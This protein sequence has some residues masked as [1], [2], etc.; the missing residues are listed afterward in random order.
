M[1]TEKVLMEVIQYWVA[2][3][4]EQQAELEQVKKKVEELERS[5]IC[6]KEK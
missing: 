6:L 5:V 1:D 2:R 4:I 3:F